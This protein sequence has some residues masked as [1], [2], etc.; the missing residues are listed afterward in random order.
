M[1]PSAARAWPE[2]ATDRSKRAR[3][4]LETVETDPDNPEPRDGTDL[5]PGA[6]PMRWFVSNDAILT[7][8]AAKPAKLAGGANA[9]NVRADARTRLARIG[10][11]LCA[12]VAVGA[13]IFDAIVA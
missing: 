10:C 9:R 1:E 5:E 2:N 4:L 3:I 8:D 12:I 6:S 7:P 11:L 13:F